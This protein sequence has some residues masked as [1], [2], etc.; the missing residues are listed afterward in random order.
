[1][2]AALRS[3]PR[4][5]NVALTN[6]EKLQYIVAVND[7]EQLHEYLPEVFLPDVPP[8]VWKDKWVFVF[9]CPTQIALVS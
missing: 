7:P 2:P 4:T 1:M 3:A 8:V 6:N 5:V 9:S